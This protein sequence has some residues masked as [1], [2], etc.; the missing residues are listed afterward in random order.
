M[1][2][3]GLCTLEPLQYEIRKGFWFVGAVKMPRAVD[4][5]SVSGTSVSF[6]PFGVIRDVMRE[7]PVAGPISAR[8]RRR[9]AIF[10]F[11]QRLQL[12]GQLCVRLLRSKLRAGG[13]FYLKIQT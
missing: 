7:M 12:A 2:K 5:L 8:S 11:E 3:W 4:F 6:R 10:I 1:L 9:S 13:F